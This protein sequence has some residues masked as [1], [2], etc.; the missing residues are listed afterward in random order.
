MISK[1]I[2]SALLFIVFV[3]S[4]YLIIFNRTGSNFSSSSPTDVPSVTLFA[5]YLLTSTSSLSNAQQWSSTFLGKNIGYLTS[6]SKPTNG[7]FT[8]SV[9]LPNGPFL[10][11]DPGWYQPSSIPTGGIYTGTYIGT[12]DPK[13]ASQIVNNTSS[14]RSPYISNNN[15]GTTNDGKYYSTS[16]NN[17]P[18]P[19]F[20]SDASLTLATQLEV[21]TGQYTFYTSG[22]AGTQGE[23]G[24]FNSYFQYDRYASMFMNNDFQ[25]VPF[26]TNSNGPISMNLLAGM[27]SYYNF[28]TTPTEFTF[29]GNLYDITIPNQIQNGP[30][31]M[32]Y[33]QVVGIPADFAIPGYDRVN[34]QGV[35]NLVNYGT[36]KMTAAYISKT[37]GA[38][39]NS[40]LLRTY[41]IT[42]VL[43]ATHWLFN[44]SPGTAPVG[45]NI[46]NNWLG[47]I[48]DLENNYAPNTIC[49]DTN[50]DG[51]TPFY[52]SYSTLH[53][54]YL[55]LMA[56]DSWIQ[57]QI[58]NVNN[59]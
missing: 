4:L 39:T 13:A 2:K 44:G 52:I 24:A 1:K 36:A 20:N 47:I 35:G 34:T 8:G 5:N 41:I 58:T 15:T 56:R 38:F 32:S 51:N 26:T 6:N 45:T 10:L 23:Y 16:I 18:N 31:S 28:T 30:T 33:N 19:F 14:N 55:T 17:I 40:Q 29:K 48:T 7:T 42:G 54:I 57:N 49:S 59:L 21:T 11:P 37:S 12:T 22:P 46:P 3:I 50:L 43:A 25:I 27:K 9:N 53:A